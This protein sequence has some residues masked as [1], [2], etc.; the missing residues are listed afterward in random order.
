MLEA[1]AGEISAKAFHEESFSEVLDQTLASGGRIYSAAYIMPSAVQFGAERK[2]LNHLRLL[3]HLL[4]TGA[5]ESVAKAT[6]LRDVFD[7]LLGTPS[8]GPFLA[9]QFATDL[10]YSPELCFPEDHFV[11]PGPGAQDGIAKCFVDPGDLSLPDIVR[12]TMETQEEQFER[13]G[14]R[15]DDLWG[16]PLQLIDC[17]N[18]FC[19]VSKYARA[20]HPEYPGRA[21]RTRIKQRFHPRPDPITAWY[22]PKWGLN[23]RVSK[24]MKGAASSRL[25]AP[26]GTGAT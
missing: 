23:D 21:G 6:S 10:N 4:K 2:H 14:I 25:T 26:S 16:R 11:M 20:A 3:A 9:Y 15:F 22:P 19:E 12:W 13:R 1:Y 5:D 7:F 17:Q 18:L 24:W 8:F